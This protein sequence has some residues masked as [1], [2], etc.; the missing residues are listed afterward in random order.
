MK[1]F[2]H[3]DTDA[4]SAEEVYVGRNSEGAIREIRPVC[5]ECIIAEYKRKKEMART[6]KIFLFSIITIVVS[7]IGLNI[8]LG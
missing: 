5:Q 1:C 7:L 6:G 8:I 2:K 4:V 3:F